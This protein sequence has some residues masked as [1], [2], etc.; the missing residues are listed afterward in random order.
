MNQLIQQWKIFWDEWRNNPD[1]RYKLDPTRFFKPDV[2]DFMDWLEKSQEAQ[3]TTH[4]KDYTDILNEYH[5]KFPKIK[6]TNDY[7]NKYDWMLIEDFWLEKIAQARRD[8]LDEAI[9]V[10]NEY[11]ERQLAGIE[12]SGEYEIVKLLKALKLTSHPVRG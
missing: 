9:S 1:H 8:T 6:A 11:C 2:S 4:T 12:I 7:F 10:I 3:L 5:L